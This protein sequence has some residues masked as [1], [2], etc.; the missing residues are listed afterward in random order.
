MASPSSDYEL[1]S[2]DDYGVLTPTTSDEESDGSGSI[3]CPDD[4]AAPVKAAAGGHPPW[5]GHGDKL[6]GLVD[7]GR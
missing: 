6:V 2:E 5:R 3:D 4:V 1:I 7:M